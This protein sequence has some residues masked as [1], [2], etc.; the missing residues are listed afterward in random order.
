MGHR[1]IAAGPVTDGEGFVAALPTLSKCSMSR[2]RTTR[3]AFPN[4]R[5]MAKS[6]GDALPRF[7]GHARPAPADELSISF[8]IMENILRLV[9]IGQYAADTAAGV[10]K[11]MVNRNHMV[12]VLSVAATIG[13]E[14]TVDI[15]D[16]IAHHHVSPGICFTAL[17]SMGSRVAD[18]GQRIELLTQGL[19]DASVLARESVR[20]EIQKVISEHQPVQR[21]R[22]DSCC[23]PGCG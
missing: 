19:G 12:R 4:F 2:R 3:L 18:A 15:I 11:K 22:S 7:H 16:H 14:N 17:K 8:N 1:L 21:A 9:V 6:G 5:M 20:V 13:D 10:I 23:S